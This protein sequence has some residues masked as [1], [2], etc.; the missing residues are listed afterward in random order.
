M[1]TNQDC[2]D[3][4]LLV[5]GSALLAALLGLAAALSNYRD[6]SGEVRTFAIHCAYGLGIA[7]GIGAA[8]APIR[9]KLALLT[10]LV[11]VATILMYVEVLG[12]TDSKWGIDIPYVAAVAGGINGLVVMYV[13][14]RL[15]Q[16]RTKC[17]K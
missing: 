5:A 13:A 8:F 12:P 9:P 1:I 2:K 4:F 15:Q 17:S 7:G 11:A 14:V 10:P 3:H 16:S 6:W